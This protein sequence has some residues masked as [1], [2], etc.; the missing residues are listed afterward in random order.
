[1]VSAPLPKSG[2]SLGGGLCGT[3]SPF[4]EFAAGIGLSKGKPHKCKFYCAI[5]PS[6]PFNV[7][8]YKFFSTLSPY[9]NTRTLVGMPSVSWYVHL[10]KAMPSK[11]LLFCLSAQ[12]IFSGLGSS[13]QRFAGA[14]S[15]KVRWNFDSFLVPQCIFGL[16]G[17]LYPVLT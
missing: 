1:M 6:L 8:W 10:N 5:S 2:I 11:M 3:P 7:R 17:P 15:R 16:S 14:S 4:S 12:I 13:F 9:T